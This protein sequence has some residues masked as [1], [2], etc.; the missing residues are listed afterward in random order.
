[1]AVSASVV[2]PT[3]NGG[4]GAVI[5]LRALAAGS[6]PRTGFEV[7]VVDNASTDDV[8]GTIH[9]DRAW[10]DLSAAGVACRVVREP[11]PG[12]T[13]ARLRQHRRSLVGHYL[14]S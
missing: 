7:I 3:H 5:V 12:L 1:M 2:I 10:S 9:Q 8:A 14:L 13:T 11:T 4:A 6:R